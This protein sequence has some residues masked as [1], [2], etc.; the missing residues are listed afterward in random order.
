MKKK[1]RN[2]H[3]PLVKIPLKEKLEIIPNK[4]KYIS[5]FSLKKC[6]N[7]QILPTTELSQEHPTEHPEV[8]TQES[9]KKRQF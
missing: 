2:L 7:K 8:E 9:V 5:P 1:C 4:K 6:N 3:L